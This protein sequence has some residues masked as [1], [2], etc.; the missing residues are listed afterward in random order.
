MAKRYSI[1][2]GLNWVKIPADVEKQEVLLA[3][4]WH[5]GHFCHDERLLKYYLSLMDTNPTMLMLLLGDLYECKLRNSK[6]KPEE[7]TLS[8]RDQKKKLRASLE[9]Y[10]DR[11]IGSVPGNH[12]ERQG[13]EGGSSLTEDLCYDLG[14]PFFEPTGVVVLASEKQRACAYTLA[15]R[16]GNS[17]GTL[18]G[19]GL[20]ATHKDAWNTEADVYIEGHCHKGTVSQPLERSVVNYPNKCLTNRL[21]W[22]ITNGSL[23]NAEKS[24]GAMHGYPRTAP[25]Q[26]IVTFTM[27]KHDK[28]VNVRWK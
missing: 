15:F 5:I 19:S 17:N 2:D 18:I 4:D 22:V 6:G 27:R 8:V 25:R 24:Y 20:N 28:D 10:A 7:Q 11:I 9:P 14:A 13:Q 23:L 12:D 26:G 1:E 21:Y 16:H 3:G